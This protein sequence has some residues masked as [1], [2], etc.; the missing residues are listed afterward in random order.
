MDLLQQHASL[1]HF[2]RAGVTALKQNALSEQDKDKQA[3]IKEFLTFPENDDDGWTNTL[4]DL[5]LVNSYDVQQKVEYKPSHVCHHL[6]KKKPG[7]KT[8]ATLLQEANAERLLRQVKEGFQKHE[9]GLYTTHTKIQY[10]NVSKDK[11]IFDRLK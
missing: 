11:E 8:P 1:V 10:F 7:P 3:A 2:V 5:A 9:L 4:L 6:R